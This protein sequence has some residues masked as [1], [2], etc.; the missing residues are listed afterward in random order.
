MCV[1]VRVFI[2]RSG[3]SLEDLGRL[4]LCMG[5][6]RFDGDIDRCAPETREGCAGGE[7]VLRA[8]GGPFR[9]SPSFFRR[10]IRRRALLS[11]PMDD[12]RG[13]AAVG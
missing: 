10:K 5:R 3:F 2:V 6:V 8:P 12:D 11:S 13:P 1:C 4:L 7:N 9:A